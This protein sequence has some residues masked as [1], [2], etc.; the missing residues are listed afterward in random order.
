MTAGAPESGQ[1][2]RN[3][4]HPQRTAAARLDAA[5]DTRITELLAAAPPTT[6]EQRSA[7]V[8]AFAGAAPHT[9]T[10]DAA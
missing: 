4:G 6:D 8:R 1:D 5:I 9:D 2:T 10:S 3:T 7:V